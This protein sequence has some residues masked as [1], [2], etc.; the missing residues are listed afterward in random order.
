MFGE[1]VACKVKII[2]NAIDTEK[3]LYNEKIRNVIR[4]DFEIQDCFVVGHVGRLCYQKNSLFV[5]D[6]FKK[7]LDIERKA[8]LLMVGEGEDHGL[9]EE[10]IR[11]LGI[12][13]Q[14]IMTGMRSD[15][16]RLLQAMDVFLLPSR[17]EGLPVTVIEAQA[18]DLP[19]VVSKA[20]PLAAKLIDAFSRIDIKESAEI[21]RDEIL[22][23]RGIKRKNMY[24]CI[25]RG[26]Y[27]IESQA[28]RL[29][30]IFNMLGVCK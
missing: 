29:E 6:I 3:Y 26:G 1:K 4:D 30:K 15:V 5:L 23:M 10:R 24:D 16:D 14:V 27:D 13:D 7:V 18:A 21:W 9:V 17:F 12:A 19:L 11:E 28:E 20:T 2:R 8:M 22:K 25:V